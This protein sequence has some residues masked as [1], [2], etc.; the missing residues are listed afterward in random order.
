M[1]LHMPLDRYIFQSSSK[2]LLWVPETKIPQ[3]VKIQRITDCE[4]PTID[5]ST[6]QPLHLSLRKHHRKSRGTIW[7]VRRRDTGWCVLYMTQGNCSKK[8]QQYSCLNK[9][10]DTATPIDMSTWRGEFPKAPPL[11]EEQHEIDSC[12]EMPFSPGTMSLLTNSKRS[13]LPTY[14]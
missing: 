5:T 11:Y 14:E 12:W 2:K 1:L 13:T 3:L 9:I 7:W 4:E 10:W 8:C 6:A